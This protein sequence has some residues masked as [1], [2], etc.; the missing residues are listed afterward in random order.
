MKFGILVVISTAAAK[1]APAPDT[2]ILTGSRG[3]VSPNRTPGRDYFPP[4][5]DPYQP[6]GTKRPTGPG[7]D[8]SRGCTPGGTVQD[9]DFGTQSNCYK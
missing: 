4:T 8:G 2:D 7:P 9:T 1:F 5:A 6:G 3:T